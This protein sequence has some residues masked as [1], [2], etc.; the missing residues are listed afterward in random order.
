MTNIK[1][2]SAANLNDPLRDEESTNKATLGLLISQKEI[3]R[4]NPLQNDL[5]KPNLKEISR[6]QYSCGGNICSLSMSLDTVSHTRPQID[7]NF[8][9]ELTP[10]FQFGLKVVSNEFT[11]GI[12]FISVKLPL[13]LVFL[14][15]S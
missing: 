11:V 12:S 9:Y 5:A 6:L 13:L 2:I 1:S 15:R 4:A 3:G 10:S 14:W 7:I 8:G